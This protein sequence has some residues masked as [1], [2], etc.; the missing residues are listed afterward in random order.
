MSFESN[1]DMFCAYCCYQLHSLL[2]IKRTAIQKV[3]EIIGVFY[4]GYCQCPGKAIKYT[5]VFL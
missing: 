3:K 2:P 5:A 4:H 1:A